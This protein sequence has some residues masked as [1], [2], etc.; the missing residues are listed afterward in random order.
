MR[1]MK[2]WSRKGKNLERGGGKCEEYEED[3]E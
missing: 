3:K 2:I 1:K